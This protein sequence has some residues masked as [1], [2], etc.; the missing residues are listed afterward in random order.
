MARKWG[1]IDGRKISKRQ[2]ALALFQFRGLL[3]LKEK[4]PASNEDG[5][6]P[7][8]MLLAVLVCARIWG[9]QNEAL[10]EMN[11]SDLWSQLV[12]RY[13]A[14]TGNP[15][16]FPP[17]APAAHTLD[18][19]T[20]RVAE[21]RGLVD[22]LRQRFMV[23][24]V[25]MA[26]QLGQFKQDVEP[27]WTRID[28]KHLIIGDGTY[29]RPFSSVRETRD[30]KTDKLVILGSRA[31][32][33]PRVQR[34]VTDAAQDDKTAVGINHVTVVT[35]TRY[36][37]IVLGVDHALGSEIRTATPMIDRLTEL[38]GN[39]IH[40]VAW[41]SA[42]SG[43]SKEILTA[44]NGVFA[45]T[46]P[47]SRAAQQQL[48][49]AGA[50]L[51]QEEA[52]WRYKND[53][54]LPLGTS[55][56]PVTKGHAM[57]R[58]FV[59]PFGPVPGTSCP[60]ELWV[61]GEAL[62]DVRRDVRARPMPTTGEAAND[63]LAAGDRDTSECQPVK[64]ARAHARRATRHLHDD[65]LYGL[66]IEWS[67]PCDVA[68]EHRFSTTSSPRAQTGQA[69]PDAAQMAVNAASPLPRAHSKRFGR[70]YGFRNISESFNSWYKSRLGTTAG[71]A[72]AMRL[73]PEHQAIDHLCIGIIAN[74]NTHLRYRAKL[75]R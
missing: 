53:E 9:S 27:D 74:S 29:V 32:Y 11:D 23:S 24:S 46:K 21:T 52:V 7:D 61:D 13:A 33:Q 25:A 6:Y 56:F 48:E 3:D 2:Q 73:R 4:L 17:I 67:L 31:K 44:T 18:T 20:A 41:D 62:V 75:A 8:L 1:G 70:G 55:V 60:H 71:S 10:N 54:E 28:P 34:V 35:W 30:A 26:K 50:G 45:L 38:A 19:F 59:Y 63:P 36:G 5:G 64:V 58:T 22:E 72:R 40:T 66:T 14:A 16:P 37:W 39:G 15:G 68:G 51:S 69:T 47:V 49:Y 43:I 65:G 12:A 42:Y 57:V